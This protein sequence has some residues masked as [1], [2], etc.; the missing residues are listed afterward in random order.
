MRVSTLRYPQGGT[1]VIESGFE[2]TRTEEEV[3][4]V[5]KEKRKVIQ[6]KSEQ[7]KSNALISGRFGL[8]GKKKRGRD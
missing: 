3:A 4:I 7:K 1:E 6:G 8:A 2:K 5:F